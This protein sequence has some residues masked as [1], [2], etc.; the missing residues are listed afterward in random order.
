MYVNLCV[1]YTGSSPFRTNIGK[2]RNFVLCDWLN[3]LVGRR[4]GGEEEVAFAR[5]VG[6]G[7]EEV[8]ASFGDA[9]LSA[10]LIGGGGEVLSD[11]VERLLGHLPE[12]SLLS[13][14]VLQYGEGASREVDNLCGREVKVGVRSRLP[15]L[16]GEGKGIVSHFGKG[17]VEVVYVGAYLRGDW[18]GLWGYFFRGMAEC[19]MGLDFYGGG[20]VVSIG[21]D[22][23][24]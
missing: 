11:E 21:V 1:T 19:A 5:A 14:V 3:N 10:E 9:E 22:V 20:V 18:G 2:W 4:A 6:V 17:G 24:E 15:Y 12:P 8:G 7:D 13:E 23:E 16:E